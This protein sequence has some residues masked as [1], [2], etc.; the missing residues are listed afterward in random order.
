VL[1]QNLIFAG[2]KYKGNFTGHVLYEVTD[3]SIYL[4]NPLTPDQLLVLDLDRFGDRQDSPILHDILHYKAQ[5]QEKEC[6]PIS[7]CS[8]VK[9]INVNT[10]QINLLK[11]TCWESPGEDTTTTTISA[12]PEGTLHYGKEAQRLLYVSKYGNLLVCLD[13]GLNVLYERTT[14]DTIRYKKATKNQTGAMRVVNRLSAVYGDWLFV[15]S[16]ILADNE[17]R[18]IFESSAVIDVYTV[19]DGYYSFSFYLPDQGKEKVMDFRVNG[20]KL[21]ALYEHS[22]V[23]FR[24]NF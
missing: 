12:D 22:I 4:K 19:K 14:L 10:S 1:E 13:S 3:T 24:L 21:V 9:K 16:L 7:Q 18:K 11:K 20:K 5:E 8:C 2:N 17:V 6:I 23:I 15:N